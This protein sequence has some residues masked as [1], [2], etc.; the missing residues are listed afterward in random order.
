RDADLA[1]LRPGPSTRPPARTTPGHPCPRAT[2]HAEHAD[3]ANV[4]DRIGD[5]G[6]RLLRAPQ[7]RYGY[8]VHLHNTR[9]RRA[10]RA[11]EGARP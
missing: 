9:I 1:E 2:P 8:I 3:I 11:L 6:E 7:F 10:D 5:M 4:D